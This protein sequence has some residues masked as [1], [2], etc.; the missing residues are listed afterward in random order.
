MA[1]QKKSSMISFFHV[2]VDNSMNGSE[3]KTSPDI[4]ET[5]FMSF[6][7]FL[8]NASNTNITILMAWEKTFEAGLI[9]QSALFARIGEI[10]EILEEVNLQISSLDNL[11]E[12]R[13]VRARSVVSLFIPAV[14]LANIN[15]NAWSMTSN[16]SV[17]NCG[18]LGFLG[19]ALRPHFSENV[20]SEQ[21]VS[22]ILGVLE[23]VK[24]LL[25][26]NDFPLRLKIILKRK[27]DVLIWRLKHPEFETLQQ[28]SD[29]LGQATLTA[30]Q[31]ERLWPIDSSREAAADMRRKLFECF[32]KTS[33]VAE[34][35]GKMVVA[36]KI[37][38]DVAK[39]LL[40]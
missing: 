16:C 13:K 7:N 1:C 8:P 12:A 15:N 17:E 25:N 33:E 26:Q 20:L 3:A 36:G 23:E 24:T 18:S 40:G 14:T 29:A 2:G 19:D 5:V 11:S 27:L 9:G 38:Y 35:G 21:D 10:S 39:P 37:I 31:M 22:E 4:L 30:N 6:R 32:K 28:A 34:R